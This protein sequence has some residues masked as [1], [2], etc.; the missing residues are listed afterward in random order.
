MK[1]NITKLMIFVALLPVSAT[2]L[3]QKAQD[4]NDYAKHPQITC[5][6]GFKLSDFKL[7]DYHRRA[8]TMDYSLNNNLSLMQNSDNNSSYYDTKQFDNSFNLNA[9]VTFFDILYTR[10]LQRETYISSNIGFYLN[11]LKRQNL[12][13]AKPLK[14]N[15]IEYLLNADFRQNNRRYFNDNLFIGY[16]PFISYRLDGY[17]IVYNGPTNSTQNNF[18]QALNLG[19]GLEIGYG[20]IEQVGDARHAIYI[21]DALARQGLTTTSKSQEDIIRFA[22]LIAKLKN[23]RFLDSRHRKIYELEALDSFLVANNLIN[24]S[25]ARYFTT[26]QDFWMYGNI[27]RLSGTRWSLFAT[28]AYGFDFNN[29]KYKTDDTAMNLLYNPMETI[30]NENILSIKLGVSFTYEKPISL[31]WQNSISSTIAY[32]SENIRSMSKYVNAIN[33]KYIEYD[34]VPGFSYLFSQRFS[35]YPTTRTSFRVGYGFTYR[36]LFSREGSPIEKKYNH[37]EHLLKGGINGGFSYYFSPQLQ[38]N[39]TTSLDYRFTENDG[40]YDVDYMIKGSLFLFR[41][42]MSLNYTFY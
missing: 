20:R 26:L 10:K 25:N 39:L 34:F 11:Y 1:N 22:E 38:L 40:Y 29:Y 17:N 35:Y 30:S 23:K 14:N 31:Y 5:N 41:F 24:A 9:S 36:L 13:M 16:N 6:S 42:N 3:S 18:S 12:D 32:N 21:F 27:N 28:P 37:F 33:S 2:M 7:P 15:R 8:L 19:I 4:T